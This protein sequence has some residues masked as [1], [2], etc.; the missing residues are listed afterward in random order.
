VD[1]LERRERHR[2]VVAHLQRG[3]PAEVG[4][5]F[6]LLLAVFL[7]AGVHAQ[8]TALVRDINPN[9]PAGSPGLEPGQFAASG[10]RAVFDKRPSN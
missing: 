1:V 6:A 5:A 4:E 2:E 7:P 3:V 9:P 10:G 8:T